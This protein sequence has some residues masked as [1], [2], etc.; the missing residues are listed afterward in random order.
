[1]SNLQVLPLKLG[2]QLV[3]IFIDFFSSKIDYLSQKIDYTY[4]RILAPPKPTILDKSTNNHK[5]YN[6]GK[7]FTLSQRSITA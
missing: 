2:N 3:S 1:M 4:S 6:F 5:I 7:N